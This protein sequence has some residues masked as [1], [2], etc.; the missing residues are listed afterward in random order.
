MTLSESVGD[1]LILELSHVPATRVTDPKQ[2][3]NRRR[4][5]RPFD[6]ASDQAAHVLRK[7]NPEVSCSPLG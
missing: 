7:G 6:I 2:V 4:M 3:V 1:V 5:C